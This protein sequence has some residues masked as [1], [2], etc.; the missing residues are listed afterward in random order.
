MNER[1]TAKVKVGLS[2]TVFLLTAILLIWSGSAVA[3]QSLRDLAKEYGADWLAGRWTATTDEGATIL[4]VYKWEL[5]GHLLTVDLRMGEYASRG[6][7]FYVPGEEKAIEVGVDNR[8]GRT[9]GTWEPQDDR[10]VSKR[11]HV[12][13]EGKV[14]KS[15]AVYS[16][17]DARTMKIA[18][19]GL[20]E[21]GELN[22]E[23]WFTMDF[24]RK[25]RR[26]IDKPAGKRQ[27]K[28]N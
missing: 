20:D 3:Q 24:K 19:Y 17:V 23:P 12:D 1:K 5:D 9:R 11:E 8:G 4:L 28:S 25:A 15:A 22:D 18:L 13:A 7:S 2:K 16:K 6:M 10:L 27:K 21:N 26:K 14:R